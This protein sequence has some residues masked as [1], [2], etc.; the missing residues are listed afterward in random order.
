M[1]ISRGLFFLQT[2][3]PQRIFPCVVMLFHHVAAEIMWSGRRLRDGRDGIAET[4]SARIVP[5]APMAPYDC[6]LLYMIQHTE[7]PDKS[8]EKVKVMLHEIWL[9]ENVAL[10]KPGIR[11][12]YQQ[13]SRGVCHG[14]RASG[15]RSSGPV[16]LLRLPGRA[17][18]ASVYH[19][20]DRIGVRKASPADGSDEGLWHWDDRPDNGA[21]SGPSVQRA[22]D[23]GSTGS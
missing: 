4:Q 13:L 12:I 14:H 5:L 23:T 3:S 8:G 7:E 22:N 11:S 21:E 6:H 19:Q 20:S 17:Q 15:W 16:G 9:A 18:R 10:G 2:C 1:P